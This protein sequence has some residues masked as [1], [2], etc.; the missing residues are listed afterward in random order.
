MERQFLKLR[1]RMRT[2]SERNRHQG[3]AL[4]LQQL[5]LAREGDKSIGGKPWVLLCFLEESQRS[6]LGSS[7]CGKL[8]NRNSEG[9]KRF[10][11]SNSLRGC[12][13]CSV[14]LR[15]WGDSIMAVNVCGRPVAYLRANQEAE[16]KTGSSQGYY[17]PDPRD[18]FPSAHSNPLRLYNILKQSHHLGTKHGDDKASM[19]SQCLTMAKALGC[20]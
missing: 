18:L 6:Q 7:G 9:K 19:T 15:I 4:G 3:C 10:S 2:I 12:N 5:S 11:L 1:D 13:P 17:K 20:L 8:S 16:D 14:D